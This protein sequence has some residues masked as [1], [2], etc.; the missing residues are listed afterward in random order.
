MFENNKKQ[1][2]VKRKERLNLGR[3]CVNDY[4]EPRLS[5]FDETRTV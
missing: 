5:G 3:R 2:K 1:Q 4:T